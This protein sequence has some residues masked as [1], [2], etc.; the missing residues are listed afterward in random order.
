M[1]KCIVLHYRKGVAMA[2]NIKTIQSLERA[3]NILKCFEKKEELGVTEISNIVGLHKSTTYN[4]ISTLEHLDLLE[5]TKED[6]KYKLG[7]ELFRLGT[8][9]NSNLRSVAIPY[10]EK[11]SELFSETVNL[12]ARNGLKVIY[13]EKMDSTHS[14][15]IS[16]R[17]GQ[18]LPLHCTG[19]G[20]A[21]IST[22]GEEEINSITK[23]LQ[24]SKFTQ[25]TVASKEELIEQIDKARKRGYSEDIQELEPGLTCVAAPI[26]DHTG[27]SKFAISVSGPNTRM[28]KEVRRKIGIT[29]VKYTEE[30]SRKLG[31]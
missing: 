14:M 25:Y 4:L 23:N 17:E 1:I 20:K 13:L 6:S 21:I 29:L 3:Y 2:K 8:M 12:V 7:M 24:F 5:K 10:L 26:R 18:Q 9:V 27:K 31:Y 15:R 19:V 30:I 28:T 22:L 11:L 16:T